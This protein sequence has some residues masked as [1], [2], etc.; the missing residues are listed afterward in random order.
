MT[1]NDST[2]LVTQLWLDST[3]SWLD[4][5]S[6]PK[7][8][9]WLWI[10]RLVTLT[11]ICLDKNDSGTSLM[12]CRFLEDWTGKLAGLTLK[13]TSVSLCFR[14]I[15]SVDCHLLSSFC[16]DSNMHICLFKYVLSTMG[17]SKESISKF[18]IGKRF[19]V[20]LDAWFYV[21]SISC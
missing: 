21:K 6:T 9:R 15:E 7:K 10:E 18:L 20:I 2:V 4:S 5:K 12:A 13:S 8:F 1:R 19:H 14:G 16:D 3:K 11:R 17:V